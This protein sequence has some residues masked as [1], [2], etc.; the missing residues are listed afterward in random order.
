MEKTSLGMEENIEGALCYVLGWVTG[1]VFYLLEKENKFV[2]FHAM[3]SILTFL[4]LTVIYWIFGWLLW[5]IP[6][7]GWAISVLIGLLMFILWIVLMIKAYQGEKFKLPIV[8]DM[9][10]KGF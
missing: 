10:E 3:Q 5:W 7:I 2:R 4:P 8:G 1:I 9:A 6:F